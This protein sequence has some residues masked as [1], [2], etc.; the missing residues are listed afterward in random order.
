LATP[1]H[2]PLLA[3]LLAGV[4]VVAPSSVEEPDPAGFSEHAEVRL[5]S[6]DL[7]LQPRRGE[8][9]SAC[10]EMQLEQ[11]S[12]KLR[13]EQLAAERLVALDREPRPT[14]HALLIDTS[15]SMNGKLDFVRETARE[16]LDTLDPQFERALVA[17]FD[18]SVI[19]LQAPTADRARLKRAVDEVRLGGATAL[20]DGLHAVLGELQTHRDR[21][22]VLLISDG[23]D[24]ASFHRADDVESLARELSDLTVFAVGLGLPQL[25]TR[26][27]NI[28]TRTFLQRLAER[29]N[30]KFFNVPTGSRLEP[31]FR[32]VRA[33]LDDE[34]QLS[35]L[36]PNPEL[37]P[38][39]VRVRS[40]DSRCR[41]SLFRPVRGGETNRPARA[42]EWSA[43]LGPSGIT[44]HVLDVTM[45]TGMLYSSANVQR[46][47]ANPRLVLADRRFR[48]PLP[49]P[50]KLPLTPAGWMDELAALALETRPSPFVSHFRKRPEHRHARPY[51]E[52]DLLWHGRSFLEARSQVAAAMLRH[53]DYRERQPAAWLGDVSALRLFVDW[54]V[55]R[56]NRNLLGDGSAD[57]QWIESWRALRRW[58]FVP[59]YA[60]TLALSA[61]VRDPVEDRVGFWRI[62]LPRPSWMLPRLKAWKRRPVPFDLLPDLPFGYFAMRAL[63]QFDP[64]RFDRWRREG[65]RVT[66]VRYR[67]LVPPRKRDPERAFREIRVEIPLASE[68]AGAVTLVAEMLFETGQPTVRCLGLDGVRAAIR[69]TIDCPKE[70]GSP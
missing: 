3:A 39:K 63:Q 11:L 40:L 38:G 14:L 26:S 49:Q 42:S 54:E 48:I 70:G 20:F 64:E 10:R 8:L 16:Y 13:G 35:F 19:L 25:N 15:E 6:V 66:D 34:A 65:Y 47:E 23:V 46:V 62:V 59:S 17:T 28:S 61:P 9:P 21:S 36:D 32:R 45:E 7:R 22:V 68:V 2:R 44:G 69:G 41:A 31:T 67:T 58:L 52:L 30:G 12:V 24:T 5:H 43:E 4:A 57:P 1:R 60:R 56:I 37:P 50:A 55:G 51:D 18:E 27:G 29:T 33:M 53:P